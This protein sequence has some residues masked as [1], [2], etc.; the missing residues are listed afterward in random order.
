M[1]VQGTGGMTIQWMGD[2]PL[3]ADQF[4]EFG[5]TMKVRSYM[6]PM[7]PY[8]VAAPRPWQALVCDSSAPQSS[9]E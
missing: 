6:L 5:L 2:A 3:P 7:M 1:A 4:M 9:H 8:P